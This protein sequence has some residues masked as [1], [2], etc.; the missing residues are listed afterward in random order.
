MD[1]CYEL[2]KGWEC[3]MGK[4]KG[5]KTRENKWTDRH[6][7]LLGIII[8]VISSAISGA[9]VA[10][11]AFLISFNILEWKVDNIDDS[12]KSI[13]NEIKEMGKDINKI[14]VIEEN[15]KGIDKRLE[16]LENLTSKTLVLKLDVE[17]IPISKES[18]LEYRLSD[19]TWTFEEK[20][21]IDEK[22]GDKYSAGEL[23]NREVL[24]SYTESGTYTIFR[25]KFNI[26]NNWDGDCLINSYT[27]GSLSLV[28]EA[29]YDDGQLLNYKQII[30][31]VTSQGE[32]AWIV[33][34]REV[35]GDYNSGNSWSYYRTGDKE[36][37]FQ[38]D[39]ISEDDLITIDNFS[40]IDINR[41]EGFYHGNTSGGYYNDDTGQA[42]LVKY[43]KNGT[44]RT[45]YMGNMKDGECEDKT[46]KAWSISRDEELDE[47]V[48]Y[49]G[50]FEDNGKIY[51]D[52]KHNPVVTV[53]EIKE[54]IKDYS[55]ECEMRWAGE[56]I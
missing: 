17:Q 49:I 21:A 34:D 31:Y 28:M 4:N 39:N 13:K 18:E 56:S 19:P 40:E 38:P 44:I 26:N 7:I 6:P 48:Y 10:V 41:L 12:V 1:V 46:G 15:A 47:Y 29:S 22:N 25:G 9:V 11:I 27:D 24:L 14:A 45:L 2:Y 42:Y 55:F 51:K 3:S 35:K 30:P 54:I 8:S 20:I 52:A 36:I 5:D 16:I 50:T 53:D 37:S 33:S 43:G 23:V 32:D